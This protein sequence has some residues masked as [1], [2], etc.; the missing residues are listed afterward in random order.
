MAMRRRE[1]FR[2]A[3]KGLI[4]GHILP[5]LVLLSLWL[6]LEVGR[7]YATAYAFAFMLIGG[8]LGMVIGLLIVAAALRR[9]Y[10]AK[11]R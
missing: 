11:G 2:K 9:L 4:V 3:W 6:G 10:P 7:K 8:L 5:A 1:F